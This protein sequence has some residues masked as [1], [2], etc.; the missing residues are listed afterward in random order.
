MFST[1][2]VMGILT[3]IFMLCSNLTTNMISFTASES[4]TH[5]A[6][7]LDRVILFCPFNHQVTDASRTY[8][9]KPLRLFLVTGS[10]E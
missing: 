7:E 10:L 2:T 5:L 4:T 8:S 6:S 3:D 1:I 9:T